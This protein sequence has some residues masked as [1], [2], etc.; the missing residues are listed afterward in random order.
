MTKRELIFNRTKPCRCGCT[1]R[2]P[3]HQAT[4]RRVV[5]DVRSTDDGG[6]EGIVTMLRSP[7]RVVRTPLVSLDWDDATETLTR[8]PVLKADGTRALSPW[9]IDRDS[10][11]D[12]QNAAIE[13]GE[14]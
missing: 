7:V 13:R 9:S 5:R 14:G 11:I 8:K 6:L 3:W 12:A 10:Y 1:G 2:D 4:Y